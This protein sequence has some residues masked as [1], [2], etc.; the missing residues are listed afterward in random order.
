M[1]KYAAKQIAAPKPAKMPMVSSSTPR[2]MPVAA[3]RPAIASARPTHIWPRTCSF[4]TK[5]AQRA[6]R[7]GAWYSS[8]NAIPTGSRSI[9]TK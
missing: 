6:T 7:I 9:A 8:S 2:P 1:R 3:A 4:C 5:R